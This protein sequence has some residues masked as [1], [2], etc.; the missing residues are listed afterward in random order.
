MLFSWKMLFF[1]TFLNKMKRTDVAFPR[2]VFTHEF[3]LSISGS[4]GAEGTMTPAQL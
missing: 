2:G 4:P 3:Q 1:L